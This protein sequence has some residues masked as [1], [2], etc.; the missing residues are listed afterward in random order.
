MVAR[1]PDSDRREI[2]DRKLPPVRF[3]L[4]EWELGEARLEPLDVR[5]GV[6]KNVFRFED[7]P[8]LQGLSIDR[9]S[10]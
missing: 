1:L 8:D 5:A 2:S 6:S 9:G 7:Q 10:P 4:D 3:E